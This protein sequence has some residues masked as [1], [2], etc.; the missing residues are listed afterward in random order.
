MRHTLRRA[1]PL[2][3]PTGS[4]GPPDP[5][6]GDPTLHSR[7][8][9]ASVLQ[10]TSVSQ[11]GAR[12]PT[13]ITREV[14]LPPRGTQQ[15]PRL[16]HHRRNRGALQTRGRARPCSDSHHLR[17]DKQQEGRI[18]QHR[19]EGENRRMPRTRTSAAARRGASTGLPRRGTP[20]RAGA[21]FRRSRCHGEPPDRR[22]SEPGPRVSGSSANP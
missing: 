12:G 9:T 13:G 14:R 8:H 4:S 19:S 16:S 17:Q 21:L 5:E 10:I 18:S 20:R 2:L 1:P 15:L 11:Q 7:H 6:A 3:R 22:S